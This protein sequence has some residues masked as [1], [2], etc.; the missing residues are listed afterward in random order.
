MVTKRGTRIG[1]SFRAGGLILAS[2]AVLASSPAPVA[3]AQKTG[4]NFEWSKVIAQG[5]EIEIKGVNG[6]IEAT[7][8]SGNAVDVKAVKTARRSDPDEV[9]IEVI[10]HDDGVTICAKYPGSGNSCGPA[11]QGQMNTH[12][13]D[14]RV[15]FTVQVPAGVRLVARTVNGGIQAQGLQSPVEAET[16]NGGVSVT[17]SGF[18]SAHTVNGSIEASLGSANWP[19]SIEFDTVNGEI[20]LKLPAKLDTEV[21]ARTVNGGIDTDFPI[22][23]QGKFS[24]H[25]LHGTIG[26]GGRRLDI[27]TVNGGI[28]LESAS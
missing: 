21:R 9:T 22:T 27:G 14:V 15:D 1:A 5:K 7:R 20:H 25:Q 23:V 10:E 17:T 24:H 8:A 3:A 13:N 4:K 28:V 26:K 12:N 6:D 16:V 2:V 19:E 18:A 11:N